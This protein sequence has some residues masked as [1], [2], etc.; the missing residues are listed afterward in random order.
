MQCG[1][2]VF[3]VVTVVGAAVVCFFVSFLAFVLC[4]FI[5]PSDVLFF[6]FL[7]RRN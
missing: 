3:V 7:C 1:V 2:P 5:F 4:F 6:V